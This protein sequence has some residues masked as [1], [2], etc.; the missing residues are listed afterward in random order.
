MKRIAVLLAGLALVS[1][2]SFSEM[3]W[4]FKGTKVDF[5]QILMDSASETMETGDEIDFILKLKKDIDENTSL[6][7]KYDTDDSNPDS[8]G[9]LLVKRK[10]SE[11]ITAQV[12]LDLKTE[13]GFAIE[14]D[15]DSD[16]S[17]IAFKA[18]DSLT[19]K[20]MPLNMDMNVGDEFETE[21]AIEA[22]G[23]EAKFKMSEALKVTVGLGTSEYFDKSEENTTSFNLKAKAEYKADALSL[24]AIFTTN[25]QEAKKEGAGDTANLQTAI[26]VISGYEMG[27]LEITGE[28]LMTT[29]NTSSDESGT[30]I[31]VELAYS[32]GELMEGIKVV[33]YGSFK[34]VDENVYFDDDDSQAFGGDAH[35]GLSVIELGAKFKNKGLTVKPY[36]ELSTADNE[37]YDGDDSKTVVGTVVE[38]KF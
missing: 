3:K 13:N 10:I 29:M 33:P 36:V 35:G 38:V 12:D 4:D 30:A 26:S 17:Y 20:F 9:E 11:Y 37:I 24:E 14:E 1:G 28:L 23:I 16:K 18:T 2:I 6:A 8:K 5:E 34:S 7:I 22:G 19:V 25:T 31:F 27:A 15:G 21:D 32:L